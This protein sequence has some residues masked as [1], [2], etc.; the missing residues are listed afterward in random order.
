MYVGFG[1]YTQAETSLTCH[2]TDIELHHLALYYLLKTLMQKH[3]VGMTLNRDKYQV[4]IGTALCSQYVAN[5]SDS[6]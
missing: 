3:G 5:I 4:D 6:S 1:H 2:L